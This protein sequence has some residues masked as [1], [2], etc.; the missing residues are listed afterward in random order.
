MSLQIRVHSWGITLE[1]VHEKDLYRESKESTDIRS[2]AVY[3]ENEQK[4]LSVVE[5]FFESKIFNSD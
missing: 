2:V 1:E 3:T 5:N 4:N